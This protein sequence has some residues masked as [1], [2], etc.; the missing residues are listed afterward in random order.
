MDV[1]STIRDPP[2][3]STEE[4]KKATEELKDRIEGELKEMD[5]KYGRVTASQALRN[6]NSLFTIRRFVNPYPI[7]DTHFETLVNYTDGYRIHP[8]AYEPDEFV[9]K[10][11]D[12]MDERGETVLGDIQY[13]Y[14]RNGRIAL[15]AL[16][17][18][19]I[20]DAHKSGRN[21]FV[22]DVVD[23]LEVRF[24]GDE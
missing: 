11:Y 24:D 13:I 18:I 14:N 3:E 16:V 8:P 5:E 19:I 4:T 17:D 7:P 12:E 23:E 6:I 2:L 1:E 22:Q 21:R 9:E 15:I 20:P 10:L